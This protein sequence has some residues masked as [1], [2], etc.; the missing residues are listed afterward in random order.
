MNKN[1]IM[2]FSGILFLISPVLS[3][4]VLF[5]PVS[6]GDFTIFLSFLIILFYL[7]VSLFFIYSFLLS[8]FVVVLS[9][10]LFL[11]N[12]F[13]PKSFWRASF[14]LLIIPFFL[15]IYRDYYSLFFKLYLKLSYIFSL[16][17]IFQVSIFYSLGI[18]WVFQLPIKTYE[19]DTLNIIDFRSG[20]FRAA[21]VFKEPSYFAI[22]TIP[23]LI[24]YAKVKNFKK[25]LFYF[26]SMLASTSSLGIGVS[27]LSLFIFISIGSIN[28]RSFLIITTIFP[29]FLLSFLFYMFT[30]RNIAI[31]RFFELG[32]GGGSLQERF[33]TIFDVVQYFTFFID[34]DF[35]YKI[36]VASDGWYNS[37]I[38]LVANFGLL[39]L[40]PF[41]VFWK[42]IGLYSFSATLFLLLLTHSFSNSFFTVF[43]ILFYYVCNEFYLCNNSNIISKSKGS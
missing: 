12:D 33:F 14:F 31:L 22:F 10:L 25:Y 13:I 24:Y 37:F 34:F 27:I 42:K 8:F 3:N 18:D 43:L 28:K 19:L 40:L 16:V 32:Q 15:S 23:A 5:G 2:K 7:K 29:I 39:F 4:Y 17:L 9:F 6:I 35:S 21:G 1:F 38:Y 11:L 36:L 41:F 30:T 20:G 26:V